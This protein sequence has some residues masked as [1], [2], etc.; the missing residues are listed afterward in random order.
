MP[1]DSVVSPNG[2]YSFVLQLDGNLVQYEN[3]VLALW[4]SATAGNL[5]ILD[6]VMQTDGNLVIYNAS[7]NPLWESQ[8]QGHDG[9][10]LSVQDG[11]NVVI[12]DQEL[13]VWRTRL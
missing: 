3:K 5:D 11:G 4:E 6:V 8:T 13:V 2:A 7:G 12:Y 9:A 1:G 10:F